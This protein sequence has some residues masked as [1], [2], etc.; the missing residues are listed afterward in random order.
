MI[1]HSL[2]KHRDLGLLILRLGIGFAFMA[3]GYPKVMGGPEKWALI[4]GAVKSIGIDS[5]PVFWGFMAAISEFFGGALLAVG[6]FTRPA[7]FLLLS[8]MCVAT[9]MHLGKGDPFVKYSHALEVGILFLSLIF[10]GPG[11]YS[12]D[13]TLEVLRRPMPKDEQTPDQERMENQ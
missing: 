11:K 7:C 12:W 4:G 9:A 5:F 10:I 1:L 8:T 13:G 3:H 6:L 2:D